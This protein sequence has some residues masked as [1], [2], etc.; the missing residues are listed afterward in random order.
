M[1]GVAADARVAGAPASRSSSASARSAPTRSSRRCPFREDD[2]WNGYPEETNAPYGLAKKMLLVQSQ[3]YRAAVRLQRD[4]P[5]AGQPLRPGRQLRPARSS[6]VI[7]ALIRKVRRGAASAAA[8]EIVRLGR[9]HARRAS[10]STSRTRPE[11]IVL[12]A[13]RYDGA[14]PV[15]LGAGIRDL[16]SATSSRSI[17]RADGLHGRASCWDTTKPNGQPR[18][19]LDTTRAEQRF[20]FRART[21]FEDGLRPHRR[22]VPVA[23]DARSPAMNWSEQSILVTGGTGSFGESSSRSSCA[24][25]GPESS[26]SS[27]ATS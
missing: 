18:R 17:A 1:M 10:S 25:S 21:S 4:L 13:E 24:S 16:A 26:S 20:G 2:L 3:A 11:A 5:A 9:R 14:E 19:C 8:P 22:V 12:A 6:H 23:A 7:P 27:A 15:N